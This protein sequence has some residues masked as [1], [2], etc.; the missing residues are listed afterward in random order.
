METCPGYTLEA[1]EGGTKLHHV[2]E[3]RLFGLFKLM[4]PRVAR[5]A[6][7]ERTRTVDALKNSME[8][9]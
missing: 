8:R 1:I 9:S 3:G 4:Q 2:A 6:R 5:I 7:E